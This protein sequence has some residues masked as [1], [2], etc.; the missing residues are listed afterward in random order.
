[1]I[2]KIKAL[3][4]IQDTSKDALLEVLIDDAKAFVL[5][6][7]NIDAY[8][9]DLDS[10][11]IRMVLESYNKLGAEGISNRNYSGISESYTNDYS[12]AIYKQL[13][14]YRRIRLI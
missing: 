5:V 13:N 6:Y 2:D 11:V 14:L 12:P 9:T 3:L 7:C 4:N 10:I 8:I 1:M